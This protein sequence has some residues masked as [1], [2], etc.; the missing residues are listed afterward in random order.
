MQ[1]TATRRYHDT[2][3][4]P[5]SPL[6]TLLS[7]LIPQSFPCLSPVSSS[8]L[9][10]PP[11]RATPRRPRRPDPP[12][13]PIIRTSPH[14]T[15][16]LGRGVSLREPKPLGG[17]HLRGGI[18][19]LSQVQTIQTRQRARSP[20][21]GGVGSPTQRRGARD[22]GG[23]RG[24]SLGLG[25]LGGKVPQSLGAA[26]EAGAGACTANGC[27]RGDRHRYRHRPV[28]RTRQGHELP[29]QHHHNHQGMIRRDTVGTDEGIERHSPLRMDV[30]IITTKME[31][32][33]DHHYNKGKTKHPPSPL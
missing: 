15:R 12:H 26:I 28:L 24:G 5:I 22:Y 2:T 25:E 18:R 10:P 4:I 9:P 21:A 30:L 23:V 16:P 20:I 32:E 7:P 19:A 29:A 33:A 13:L 17:I 14:P 27:G 6:T 1:V 31:G 8:P 11:L 3:A